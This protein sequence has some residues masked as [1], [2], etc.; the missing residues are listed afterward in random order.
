MK[1]RELR[2]AK[3]IGLNQFAKALELA[4]SYLSDLET[5]KKTNPSKDVMERIADAL[6]STVPEVFYEL[7]SADKTQ[8]GT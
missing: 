6:N 8:R 1:L 3:K 5:G 7:E 4:P 2:E